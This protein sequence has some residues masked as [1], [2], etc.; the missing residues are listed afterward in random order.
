MDKSCN[1][2]V[3]LKSFCSCCVKEQTSIYP[4]KQ[5]FTFIILV[6]FAWTCNNTGI[7]KLGSIFWIQSHRMKYI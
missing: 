3:L 1:S 4:S 2:K 6:G 7:S 5:T